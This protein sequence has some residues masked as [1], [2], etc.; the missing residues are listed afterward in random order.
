MERLGAD[1]ALLTS[2]RGPS[3]AA[4]CLVQELGAEGVRSRRSACRRTPRDAPPRFWCRR[5]WTEIRI[6]PRSERIGVVEDRWLRSSGPNHEAPRVHDRNRRR[7]RSG[8]CPP[9]RRLPPAP[10]SRSGSGPLNELTSR[11]ATV[12]P[13]FTQRLLPQLLLSEIL[14]SWLEI[15]SWSSGRRCTR[16]WVN[17]PAWRS[18]TTWP[19]RTDRRRISR[20]RS[21]CRRTCWPTTWTCWRRPV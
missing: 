21:V 8:G 1:A 10:R 15:R 12:C 2:L 20:R 11:S 3:L 4:F 16:R 13:E 17:R 7:A 5:R 14:R 9:S 18:S 6:C 19:P